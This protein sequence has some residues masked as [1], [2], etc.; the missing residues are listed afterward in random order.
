MPTHSNFPRR[1]FEGT[2]DASYISPR[3]NVK[4]SSN[5]MFFQDSA[6]S[7]FGIGISIMELLSSCD[8]EDLRTY[9]PRDQTVTSDSWNV[10]DSLIEFARGT[11]D[12]KLDSKFKKNSITSSLPFNGNK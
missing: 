6:R 7:Y 8:P 10:I 3:L 1:F 5:R 12:E 11:Q 9:F 2:F 4:H